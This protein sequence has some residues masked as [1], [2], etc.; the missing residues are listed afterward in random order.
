MK[1]SLTA[2]I[3]AVLLSTVFVPADMAFAHHPTT[4]PKS[5]AGPAPMSPA[6]QVLATLSSRRSETAS[7]A[8]L[9]GY[10]YW[11]NTPPGSSAISKP[12]IHRRAGGTGKYNDPIS[13]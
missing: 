5:S 7:S 9:T 3:A 6:D 10:S 4:K 12:V 1:K 11:D 13:I 8:Y 2:F